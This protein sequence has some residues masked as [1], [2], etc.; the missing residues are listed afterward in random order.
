MADYDNEVCCQKETFT[1]QQ[2]PPLIDYTP[3]NRE[4][5]AMYYTA[6]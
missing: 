3:S 5:G 2:Y 6:Y 1:P 4:D